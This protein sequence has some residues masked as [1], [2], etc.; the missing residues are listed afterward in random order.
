MMAEARMLT[1]VKI[2]LC[3]WGEEADRSGETQ[4]E[5]RNELRV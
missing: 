1:D 5:I 4:V 2:D 3:V